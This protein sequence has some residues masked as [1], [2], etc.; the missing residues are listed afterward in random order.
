MRKYYKEKPGEI[1]RKPVGNDK[2]PVETS[3][4]HRETGEKRP[5]NEWKLTETGE[6]KEKHM[7]FYII[8]L[9]FPWND[10]WLFPDALTLSTFSRCTY[11]FK[12]H[13]LSTLW[14]T[15]LHIRIINSQPCIPTQF[16]LSLSPSVEANNF[17][18]RRLGSAA[19]AEFNGRHFFRRAKNLKFVM[20]ITSVRVKIQLN[21]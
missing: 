5:G 3:E 9:K 6:T 17:L 18:I 20:L 1:I 4:N 7:L 19:F 8:F 16:H 13:F 21:L 12:C 10:T 11:S 15:T 14:N 2:K